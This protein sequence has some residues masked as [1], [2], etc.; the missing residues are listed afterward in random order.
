MVGIAAT[1]FN[2]LLGY[3]GV[4]SYGHAMFYGIGGY[5]AALIILKIMPGHAN[6]WLTLLLAVAVVTIQAVAIG[7]L[8]VRLYGIYFALVTLAF[9]QMF[10]FIIFQWR[11]V[12]NGDNGLQNIV[13]PPVSVRAAG[14]D[15]S[16]LSA[17][18][19]QPGPLRRSL[20]D[21]DLVP[22]RRDRAHAD[23]VVRAFHHRIAVR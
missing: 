3:A 17:P 16:Q 2:L 5:T 4:L 18:G 15:R 12:T 19:P 20:G 8:V 7:A 22:F 21:Q 1:G 14:L 9:A 23:A 10:Y 6:L 11:D 13:A